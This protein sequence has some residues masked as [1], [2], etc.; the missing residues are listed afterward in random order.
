MKHHTSELESDRM[1]LYE[2][3]GD[4][5]VDRSTLA[6]ALSMSV[7]HVSELVSKG[8]LQPATLTPLRFSLEHN[9]GCIEDYRFELRHNKSGT[10]VPTLPK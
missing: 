5:I 3:Y 8:W 2:S 10:P 6:S 9:Q 1:A 7:K 4:T